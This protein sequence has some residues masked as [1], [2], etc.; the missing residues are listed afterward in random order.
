M[1]AG[2]AAVVIMLV[3]G[4]PFLTGCASIVS[5]PDQNIAFNSNPEGAAVE[6]RDR[7]NRV[8]ERNETPFTT[9]LAKSDGYFQGQTYTATFHKEG[10]SSK[11]VKITSAPS[12]WFLVGNL[13]FGGFIGWLIVDPLTG[14]MWVLSPES[15]DEA[16]WPFQVDD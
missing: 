10:Y 5:K 2:Q 8:I 16:L 1:K 6:I 7:N 4:S 9:T 3:I 11:E 13:L 15:V 14:S 12:G